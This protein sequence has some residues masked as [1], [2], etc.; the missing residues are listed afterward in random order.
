MKHVTALAALFAAAVVAAAVGAQPAAA[1]H[2]KFQLVFVQ[3]N[4]LD[5]NRIVAFERRDDGR[6]TRD[7]TYDTGGLGG[8]AA[9]GTESD[10]L[11]S[12][13]SLVYDREHRVLLA[14]N[15]GS[16]SVSVFR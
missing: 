10:R 5:G 13:G 4:E 14:V 15:A 16:D 7:G 2:D 6:L 9:P 11:A 1:K 8:I 3:T 12:Q